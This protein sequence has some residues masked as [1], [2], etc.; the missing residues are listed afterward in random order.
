MADMSERCPHCGLDYDTFR[1]GCTYRD[2]W[3]MMWSSSDDP[4]DW[5]YKR[6]HS[7]LGRWRQLKLEMWDHHIEHCP[8]R[9]DHDDKTNPF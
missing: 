7:V 9:D 1:T 2:V 4:V 5:R 8:E 6:R 3:W